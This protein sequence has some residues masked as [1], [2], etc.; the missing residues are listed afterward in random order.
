MVARSV[1]ALMMAA[2]FCRRTVAFSESGEDDGRIP[3]H[4]STLAASY[5]IMSAKDASV[6]SARFAIYLDLH[7]QR[8]AVKHQTSLHSKY[9]TAAGC[10]V[11]CRILADRRKTRPE[12]TVAP[13][14]IR[15]T[16]DRGAYVIGPD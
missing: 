12:A 5:W 4:S 14:G 8:A 13:L 9:Y 10:C 11:F 6:E 2:Y 16:V 15:Q 3:Y 1:Y 7:S